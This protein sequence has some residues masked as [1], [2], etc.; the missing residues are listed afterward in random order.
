MPIVKDGAH[1]GQECDV[2][3]LV[4]RRANARQRQGRGAG[5]SRPVATREF[6]DREQWAPIIGSA[7]RWHTGRHRRI[8]GAERLQMIQRPPTPSLAQRGQVGAE[9]IFA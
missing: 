2:N 6:G 7:I 5:A 8:M 4:L 9:V 3:G 1:V